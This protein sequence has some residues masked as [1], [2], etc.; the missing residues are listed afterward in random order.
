MD[1][2]QKAKIER[3]LKNASCFLWGLFPGRKQAE[4]YSWLR[5]KGYEFDK[6]SYNHV[7][8]QLLEKYGIERILKDLIIPEVAER[9]SPKAMDVLRDGWYMGMHPEWPFLK[10]YNI[11]DPYPFL[12]VNTQF[13]YIERWGEFAGIWFEEIEKIK[14]Q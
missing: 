5:Y 10:T 12:E 6:G 13:N 9:Y 14:E 2:E 11:R 1:D 7:T 4:V 8:S 3:Y